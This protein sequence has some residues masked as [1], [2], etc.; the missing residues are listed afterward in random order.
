MENCD[1]GS[2]KKS[3]RGT[4][5]LSSARKAASNSGESPFCE[6]LQ[7]AILKRDSHDGTASNENFTYS[8]VDPL[9]TA[10]LLSLSCFGLIAVGLS[11]LPGN[12]AGTIAFYML[13][14]IYTWARLHGGHL[15][16][17]EHLYFDETSILMNTDALP[18]KGAIIE[19]DTPA[20][21]QKVHN[22]EVGRQ[23]S[24]FEYLFANERDLEMQRFYKQHYGG[25]WHRGAREKKESDNFKTDNTSAS[26]SSKPPPSS[27]A[28]SL[29]TDRTQ[30]NSTQC[31]ETKK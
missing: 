15:T 13:L 27:S 26:A 16:R 23:L 22:N 31:S 6:T 1:A 20:D 11:F 25:M 28:S 29:V 10:S 3:T 8:Y 14:M 17:K 9:F 7:E 18:P 5:S 19:C 12:V 24:F 30:S 21:P 4:S 2:G